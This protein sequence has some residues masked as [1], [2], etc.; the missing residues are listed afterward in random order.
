MNRP[1]SIALV[2]DYNPDY[3][4][5]YRAVAV[6]QQWQLSVPFSFVWIPTGQL[7]QNPES[8]LANFSGIWAGSGPYRSKT[9]ILNGIRYARRNNVPF[10]GTC[11]GFGYAVLEFGQHLFNLATVSHPTEDGDTPAQ[12]LFLDKLATCGLGWQDVTFTPEP[13]TLTQQIYQAT[14]SI[15][16]RSHCSY[17]LH[18]A[19]ADVF[20][21]NGMV[22]S[23]RDAAGETKIIEYTPNDLFLAMLFYPHLNHHSDR[24]HPILR[25]F[26]QK[27]AETAQRHAAYA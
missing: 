15:T 2:G 10:I 1:F 22:V 20:A 17:G 6:L 12:H 24:P 27:A 21:R 23:G 16:E 7:E 11:S 26:L 19:Q 13:G 25:T 8:V 4:P 3:E 9:G 5:H 18:P 14:K